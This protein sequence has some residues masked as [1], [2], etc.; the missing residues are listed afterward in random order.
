MNKIQKIGVGISAGVGAILAL[1]VPSFA[2]DPA[3][4]STVQANTQSA[5]SG[6][7]TAA[8]TN[9]GTLIPIAAVLLISVAVVYFIVKHFR[10]LTHT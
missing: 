1:V 5:I 9:L 4:D 6:F 7:Q 2:V 10:G 3:M 8:L